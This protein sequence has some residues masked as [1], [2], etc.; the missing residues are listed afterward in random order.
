MNFAW[1]AAYYGYLFPNTFYLKVGHSL[2]AIARGKDYLL[3]YLRERWSHSEQ[4]CRKTKI[5]Y[6][7]VIKFL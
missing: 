1:R 3:S 5:R 4:N 7:Q 6:T 2:G